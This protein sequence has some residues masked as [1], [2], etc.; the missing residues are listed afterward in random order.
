MYV[1][2]PYTTGNFWTSCATPSFSGTTIFC[3]VICIRH[4]NYL[5]NAIWRWACIVGYL[6]VRIRPLW[7]LQITANKMQLFL[8]LFFFYRRSTCFRRF[9]RPSSGAHNCTY[10]FR[11]C[12]PILLLAATVEELALAI[13]STVAASSNIGWQY[14]KLYVQLC[15]WWWAEEPPETCRA[16]VKIIKFKRSCILLAVICNCITMH[17]H[18]NIKLCEGIRRGKSWLVVRNQ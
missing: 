14:L 13:S 10:S 12:Q 5:Q 8:N 3:Q 9:L 4:V 16:S 15:S 18:M 17:G 11:Y 7:G 6:A 2:D 1:R